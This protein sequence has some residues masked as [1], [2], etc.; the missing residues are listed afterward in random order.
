MRP[1]GGESLEDTLK[2]SLPFLVQLHFD[3]PQTRRQYC[4]GSKSVT[5]Y[6]TLQ[7]QANVNWQAVV[8]PGLVHGFTNPQSG[9][10]PSKIVAYN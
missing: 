9:N 8:L 6:A 10:D 5:L 1:P 4:S 7:L 3:S 2:R